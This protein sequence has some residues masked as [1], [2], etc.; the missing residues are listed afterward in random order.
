MPCLHLMPEPATELLTACLAQH[1][2]SL[3]PVDLQEQLGAAGP[4]CAA[5][6]RQWWEGHFGSDH[7]AALD[8]AWAGGGGGA[9]AVRA[10]TE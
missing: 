8:K 5:Q 4:G 9:A 2:A 6:V 10:A 3:P 7:M 1:F